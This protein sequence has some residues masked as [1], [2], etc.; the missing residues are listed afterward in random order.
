VVNGRLQIGGQGVGAFT[1]TGGT[2]AVGSPLF[3]R[4]LIVGSSAAGSYLLSGTSSLSV[5]GDEND[6]TWHV[7]AKRRHPHGERDRV[8]QFCLDGSFTL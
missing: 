6:P 5:I 2:N 7:H 4:G 1:Q 8:D 3:P